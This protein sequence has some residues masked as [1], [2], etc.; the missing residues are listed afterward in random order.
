MPILFEKPEI[1]FSERRIS[2]KRKNI[3]IKTSI[4]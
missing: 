1:Y 3:K 4:K 2:K